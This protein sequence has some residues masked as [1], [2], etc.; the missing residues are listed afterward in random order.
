MLMP[1]PRALNILLVEDDELDVENVRR[2]FKRANINSPL[3]VAADGEEALR[4]LRSSEYPRKRRLVLLDL[5]LPKMSG[6]ELL[7]QMRSDPDLHA[8]TVVVL[9]TSNEDR[10]RTEAYGLNVAGYLLKPIAFQRF[11]ELMSA[12]HNYWTLTELH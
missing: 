6:I 11:V 2:A 8:Q 4:L 3:W 5:N 1:A 9:T 10:D 7:R 12:L